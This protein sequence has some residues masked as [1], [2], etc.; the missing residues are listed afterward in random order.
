MWYE[1]LING[2]NWYINT[3]TYSS[4]IQIA[5]CVGGV[6]SEGK[7][8]RNELSQI[9]NQIDDYQTLGYNKR[10]VHLN[11]TGITKI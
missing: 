5:D 11:R 8:T 1:I 3:L 6:L 2:Y 9:N 10:L 4:K 7:Y